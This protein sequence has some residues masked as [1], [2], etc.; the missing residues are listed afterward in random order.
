[1]PKN[2][3]GSGRLQMTIWRMPIAC[4][5][6]KSTDTNSEHVTHCFSIATIV[7]WTRLY[8]TLYVHCLSCYTFHI[9]DGERWK[10]FI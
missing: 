10:C 7:V 1:M 9:W 3:L 5:I 6:P 4:W 2:I 8:V